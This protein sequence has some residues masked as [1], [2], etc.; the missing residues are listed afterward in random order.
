MYVTGDWTSLHSFLIPLWFFVLII[1]LYILYPIIEKI[2]TKFV[3]NHK[4]L[5]FL[6]FLLIVQTIYH[7]F[8]IKDN[9]LIGKTTIFIGYLFY[10]VLGMYVRSNYQN[11]KKSVIVSYNHSYFLFLALLSST[12]LGIGNFYLK[13]FR[14]DLIPQLIQI[15]TW[16]FAIVTPLFYIV[17][18]NL[19]LFLA[20]KFSEK[21]PNHFTKCLKIIGNYSFG[22]YLIHIFIWYGIAW[23]IFPKIGFDMNNWLFYPIVFTLVLSVSLCVIYILNKFPYHEYIIGNSR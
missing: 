12:I 7:G 15:Y 18:F 5:E 23:K 2:F 20:L 14:N 8:S 22:I 17:I 3:K 1:Q 6:I 10:F 16:T 11:I 13:Y 4:S 21:I 19:C 9:F